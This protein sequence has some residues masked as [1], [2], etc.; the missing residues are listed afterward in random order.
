MVK[1]NKVHWNSI[2]KNDSDAQDC[3]KGNKIYVKKNA[4]YIMIGVTRAKNNL[5]IFTF[6]DG[7]TFSRE[8]FGQDLRAKKTEAYYESLSFSD[9]F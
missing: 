7:A 5:C 1:M 8:L 3:G 6:K 4:G 9:L 2:L